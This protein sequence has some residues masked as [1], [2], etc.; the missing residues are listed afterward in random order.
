M[1]RR[2]RLTALLSSIVLLI[3]GCWDY[4]KIDNTYYVYSMGI[5]YQD[6]QY[7]VYTQMINLSQL[8]A[9][10]HAGTLGEEDESWTGV[11]KGPTILEATTKIQSSL[12][13]NVDWGHLNAVVFTEQALQHGV[14]EFFDT[15]LHFYKSRLIQWVFG[16]DQPLDEIFHTLPIIFRTPYYSLIGHPQDYYKHSSNVQPLRVHRLMQLMHEPGITVLLPKL[17]IR[18]RWSGTKE[19]RLPNL[20]IDGVIPLQEYRAK[21]KFTLQQM[22]GLRWLQ[23]D[24]KQTRLFIKVKG[25]EMAQ[26]ECHKNK[27]KIG[28]QLVGKQPKYTIQVEPMCRVLGLKKPIRQKELIQ[29]AKKAIEKEIDDTFQTGINHQIDL[30]SLSYEFYHQYP[31][32]WNKNYRVSSPSLQSI[33]V[34]P[35][36]SGAGTRKIKDT[37]DRE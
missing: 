15:I 13:N 5:D 2:T 9:A 12:E 22:M 25:E 27:T 32:R 7:V 35:R 11:G 26:L 28:L 17:G 14:K 34:I 10:T 31:D 19:N 20:T 8:S 24:I 21:G 23:E 18:Y 33:E 16:T 37:G 1:K 29:L 36:I 6:N 3:T 30:Y 4:H